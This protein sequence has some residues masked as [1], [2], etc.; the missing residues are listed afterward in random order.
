SFLRT[1]P[2]TST[3][4]FWQ[5]LTS[6]AS[7]SLLKVLT[8]IA[9][10]APREA[11]RQARQLVA[12]V[13][14]LALDMAAVC[15]EKIDALKFEEKYTLKLNLLT[16]HDAAFSDPDAVR[17]LHR[18]QANFARRAQGR[19]PLFGAKIDMEVG[20]EALYLIDH[21]ITKIGLETFLRDYPLE[22]RDSVVKKYLQHHREFVVQQGLPGKEFATLLEQLL[23][24]TNIFVGTSLLKSWSHVGYLDSGI[25]RVLP[26]WSATFEGKN[27]TL[28][29]EFFTA[30]T[31]GSDDRQNL[32]Y[33]IREADDKD[34]V[35][36]KRVGVLY[37]SYR[38]SEK[39]TK[40][41]EYIHKELCMLEAGRE[42]R[43]LNSLD[44]IVR[45]HHFEHLQ[46]PA[47]RDRMETL[48][49][50]PESALHA[51]RYFPVQLVE[52]LVRFKA[53]YQ[54]EA[55]VEQVAEL[56]WCSSVVD[57]FRY[58][59]E[60]ERT[61][62]TDLETGSFLREFLSQHVRALSS[63]NLA[64][65]HRAIALS[66]LA[67][68]VKNIEVF[69]PELV[70]AAYHGITPS[71]IA[72][73]LLLD[74]S[75]RIGAKAE[76]LSK[77]EVLLRGLTRVVHEM[78]QTD[79]ALT[80]SFD[81]KSAHRLIGRSENT[82]CSIDLLTGQSSNNKGVIIDLLN[83]L[84]KRK[85]FSHLA[86]GRQ[87]F[88]VAVR[89]YGLSESIDG[90][91]R[92]T[93]EKK[94]DVY[95]IENPYTEFWLNVS[96]SGSF[97]RAGKLEESYKDPRKEREYPVATVLNMLLGHDTVHTWR[98]DSGI[99]RHS[100][101]C[102]ERLLIDAHD[103]TRAVFQQ[104]LSFV[105]MQ[106]VD[107]V[108][109]KGDTQ[110]SFSSESTQADMKDLIERAV[111][112]LF[113]EKANSKDMSIAGCGFL[114][115][116]GVATRMVIP[117]IQTSFSRCSE[118]DIWIYDQDK[119]FKL[120]AQKSVEPLGGYSHGIVLQHVRTSAIKRV[121]LP[122]FRWSNET[123]GPDKNLG[124]LTNR[125]L[126]CDIT[127]HGIEGDRA[128]HLYLALI[129]RAQREF[130]LALQ[131]LQMS[132][133]LG[134]DGE[135]EREITQQI[136]NTPILTTE[137]IAFDIHFLL[138][139]RE[140]SQRFGSLTFEVKKQPDDVT[141]MLSQAVERY[142]MSESHYR[143]GVGAIPEQLRVPQWVL[144]EFSAHIDFEKRLT[145]TRL[146]QLE[147]RT[148]NISYNYSLTR[149]DRSRWCEDLKKATKASLN[150]VSVDPLQRLTAID[151]A[152]GFLHLARCAVSDSQFERGKVKS[153]ILSYISQNK[154]ERCES[155]EML[156]LPLLLI[157][158]E[159]P[160][161][162][163]E[164]CAKESTVDCVVEMVAILEKDDKKESKER[165]IQLPCKLFAKDTQKP[166]KSP[167]SPL[168]PL[169]ALPKN[170]PW[171]VPAGRFEVWPAKDLYELNFTLRKHKPYEK[172][173]WP[174]ANWT[175]DDAL[176]RGLIQS[177][178]SA[179]SKLQK[180]ERFEHVSKGRAL[181]DLDK[182]QAR[183]ISQVTAKAKELSLLMNEVQPVALAQFQAL[184]AAREVRE[185]TLE[186]AL[187][188]LL[189]RSHLPLIRQNPTLGEA[190]LSRIYALTIEH[191]G[192]CI[193]LKQVEEMQRVKNDA[194]LLGEVLFRKRLYDPGRYP[195]I[196]AYAAAT[197]KEPTPQQTAILEKL[198]TALQGAIDKKLVE[199]LLVEFAAG[200]GKTLLLT[201][202][203]C[204]FLISR[205]K[206][207]IITTTTDLYY[208][209]LDMLP[210]ILKGAYK[211][212][213]E[214]LDRDVEHQWTVDELV[215]LK[216]KL[217][218]WHKHQDRAI[219]MKASSWHSLNTAGKIAC[220]KSVME[221]DRDAGVCSELIVEI[222]AYFKEHGVRLEDECQE[223]S[224]PHEAT[225]RSFEVGKVVP[226]QHHDIYYNAYLV[227]RKHHVPGTTVTP[228][229]RKAIVDSCVQFFLAYEP[230]KELPWLE[231]YLRSKLNDP[232][233]KELEQLNE[234][235]PDKADLCILAKASIHLHLPHSD[236]L[237][238]GK[239]YG[240]SIHPGDMTAAPR[241][242]GRPS[243]AHF[244]DTMLVTALTIQKA[245]EV[246]IPQDH[247]EAVAKG[248]R[249][250]HESGLF[251][252][253][254]VTK[255]EKDLQQVMQNSQF[256]MKEYS[257]EQLVAAL[258]R[259][260]RH[261]WLV[262]RYLT[263]HALL[264]NR[265]HGSAA[266]STPAEMALGFN[267][268]IQMSAFVGL[269][270]IYSA[271]VSSRD[272]LLDTAFM[273]EVLAVLFQDRN[274][275]GIIMEDRTTPKAF[276][277]EMAEKRPEEFIRLRAYFDRG[278]IFANF[279]AEVLMQGALDVASEKGLSRHGITWD[280]ER[281][282]RAP[283]A[284]T[285]SQSATL[286][287]FPIRQ[288][289]G[290]DYPEL[291]FNART[292]LFLGRKV[293]LSGLGQTAMR[294]RKLLV[295]NG[296]TLFWAVM[297]DLWQ[298]IAP[299]SQQFE[300]E[301]AVRWNLRNFRDELK[302]K[303]VVRAYQGIDAELHAAA[304]K[305]VRNRDYNAR[306]MLSVL[307]PEANT[308][309]WD[310]YDRAHTV[311]KTD[312]PLRAYVV[313][314][315]DRLG[316]H[317]LS[318]E[319]KARIEK[320]VT[321]TVALIEMMHATDPATLYQ[322]GFQNHQHEQ[323]L[324]TNLQLNAYVDYGVDK[325][326]SS[327]TYGPNDSLENLELMHKGF[328]QFAVNGMA[329]ARLPKFYMPTLERLSPRNDWK[330]AVKPLSHVLVRQEKNGE[331]KYY[332]LTEAG[333]R[334]YV[335]DITKL[336][337]VHYPETRAF[338]AAI[339]KSVLLSTFTLTDKECMAALN[340]EQFAQ[341]VALLSV[342]TGRTFN[343]VDFVSTLEKRQWSRRD[344]RAFCEYI[345]TITPQD[346][347]FAT[348]KYERELF[349]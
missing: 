129:F 173:A 182:R 289:T 47:V 107:G 75:R 263:Q 13:S 186:D 242:D 313:L 309:P 337:R 185:L 79:A 203:L 184:L 153:Y 90:R 89:G 68:T 154:F 94:Q 115:E 298:T 143:E 204:M 342:A 135:L 327:E 197:G 215:I 304:W 120:M 340:C 70:Q 128:T 267:L 105:L 18:V 307:C 44:W 164:A 237:T 261:P 270:E 262:E 113:S 290:R 123:L 45:P 299:G 30:R 144:D 277:K 338:V 233:P 272:D 147:S 12:E 177:L 348:E 37:D 95:T 192:L 239:D 46:N 9:S 43:T 268:S 325:K 226:M 118:R 296:Q 245:L 104:E 329:A 24:I 281:T 85:A 234:K 114:Y 73:P 155:Y 27:R 310:L 31:K 250:E 22:S 288:T 271:L 274:A 56:E 249:D 176:E 345:R 21:I 303:I 335:E 111:P 259:L 14:L 136:K 58:H 258:E 323:S 122:A 87:K 316:L 343:S 117:S 214:L 302:S 132:C 63:A 195:E 286:A 42:L 83:E 69:L 139:A 171:K 81:P 60:Q 36:S 161:I 54:K 124:L 301:K 219:L 156:L 284:L 246:G 349:G 165:T 265:F 39:E 317:S 333:A 109:Q 287:S 200:G 88:P 119:D 170:L 51:V 41:K 11:H 269:K 4:E 2:C 198:F 150:V 282:I 175:S 102:L 82:Q 166:I 96:P 232:R 341:I 121:L 125:P 206:L 74:F 146:S 158:L 260:R 141:S 283:A 193:E 311:E 326:S 332:A 26:E 64:S 295:P 188:A 293:T 229:I 285:S 324:N 131:H 10:Y 243:S 183:L 211:L 264:Q 202:I 244:T 55:T 91:Y 52:A 189:M 3:T 344:F 174:I 256:R 241:H 80:W 169:V 149:K 32:F 201:P 40:L 254:S 315:K 291:E 330:Q 292:A 312:V 112:P 205:G 20:N 62:V 48:L 133:H 98:V 212:Q 230:L 191:Q 278:G 190:Q 57:R 23:T 273:A 7:V 209:S 224:D 334:F 305:M 134:E 253:T 328:H 59:L 116:K 5:E 108:W 72:W 92:F 138:R 33:A 50:G 225:I 93:L 255:I 194:Y 300:V 339:G 181:L 223:N 347:D 308:R 99:F 49:F 252:R 306:E 145:S 280:H 213:L 318:A 217:E 126:I 35:T 196:L 160:K 247:L 100:C 180:E 178:N 167:R 228:E 179:F 231:K 86:E 65:L 314:T 53:L 142:T 152:A 210:P 163:V 240:D 130:S 78:L 103:P 17:T 208:Q 25:L 127:A 28:P 221:Q 38:Q 218:Q 294:A 77:N 279:S 319:S 162:F 216:N 275:S 71:E 110:F 101:D 29:P 235:N 238:L 84:Q 336:R 322:T 34:D 67:V 207:P 16:G 346:E 227:A 148:N 140:H 137:A 106:L 222:L 172:S 6:E 15:A 1:V 8:K 66:H 257:D 220:Y 97:K 248:L 159:Y 331:W 266:R 76:E 199:H 276:F 297:K 321:Q 151:L 19:I 187:Q 168:A 61:A 251:K 236:S 320:I 157:V